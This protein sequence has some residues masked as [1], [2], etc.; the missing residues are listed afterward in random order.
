LLR[1]NEPDWLAY[2]DASAKRAA[3]IAVSALDFIEAGLP[4]TT[5]VAAATVYGILTDKVQILTGQ[6]AGQLS[7]PAAGPTTNIQINARHDSPVLAGAI[8]ILL[9]AGIKQPSATGSIPAEALVLTIP[10]ETV[11]DPQA[12]QSLEVRT[13]PLSPAQDNS[14]LK[15][16]P[17]L[18]ENPSKSDVSA[19]E[20]GVGHVIRPVVTDDELVSI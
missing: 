4:K 6:P 20:S 2:R 14:T 1:G 9:N 5:A 12:T 10:N 18:V 19:V 16:S 17:L 3:G 7:G 15:A 11:N 8:A 13:I